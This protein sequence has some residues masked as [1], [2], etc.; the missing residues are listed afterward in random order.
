MNLVILDIIANNFDEIKKYESIFDDSDVL[1]LTP[2]GIYYLEH[3]NIVFKFFHDLVSTEEFRNITLDIYEKTLCNN[4][5]NKYFKGYF[6]DVAQ[7]ISQLLIV[8]KIKS[9]IEDNT[10]KDVIYI[11]DKIL[12]DS[13]NLEKL[14]NTKSLLTYF[15]EFDSIIQ[16]KRNIIEN[17]VS[18]YKKLQRYSFSKLLK[19]VFLKLSKKHLKYDWAELSIVSSKIDMVSDVE[20]IIFLVDTSKTKYVKNIKLEYSIQKSKSELSNLLTFMEKDIFNKIVNLSN[21]DFYFFQHG[22]YLYKNIFIKYSE[23]EH[24][25]INFVFNDYTK[26]LFEDLGAKEVYSVGSIFF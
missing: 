2:S 7:V 17:K 25:K 24:A 1:A 26:K 18:L 20:K 5:E 3:K 16:I 23:I 11:T 4:S 22:N 10:F 15:I 19:K 8:D 9:Y 14:V 6:R 21:K 12:E 13:L